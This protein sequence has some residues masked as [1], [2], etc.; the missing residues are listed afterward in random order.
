MRNVTKGS[1]SKTRL[2]QESFRVLIKNC[3]LLSDMRVLDEKMIRSGTSLTSDEGKTMM[4]F[5]WMTLKKLRENAKEAKAVARAEE[6][7]K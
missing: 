4:W 2:Y 3:D 6:S 7:E 5:M 1:N